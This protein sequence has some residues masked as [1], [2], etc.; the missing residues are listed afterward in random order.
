MYS[1][2][3]S[4]IN[5][6]GRSPN[7]TPFGGPAPQS[8]ARQSMKAPVARSPIEKL[9]AAVIRGN[10]FS[11]R[12]LLKLAHVIAIDEHEPEDVRYRA[13]VM[14][15]KIMGIETDPSE[16]KAEAIQLYVD[17]HFGTFHDKE[18]GGFED[19]E[20]RFGHY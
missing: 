15:D 3:L 6:Y 8:S 20:N 4:S 14:M 16:S 12:D 11:D 13:L 18:D 10:A 5:E 2:R 1:M 9:E 17:E 7:F 19:E